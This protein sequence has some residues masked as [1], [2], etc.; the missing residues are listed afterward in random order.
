MVAPIKELKWLI[1][2]AN[3]QLGR[4][5][6]EQLNS[7]EIENYP[8]IRSDLDVTNRDQ[9]KNIFS[10]LKPDVVINTA[11]WTDVE[12]AESWPDEARSINSDAPAYLA[13][14]SKLIGAKFI[15]IS[16]DYV[17][18]GD[19][20][21]PWAE[22]DLPE[23]NSIYGKSKAAGEANVLFEYPESSYI[24][25]TAWLYS[26]FGNNFVK[27]IAHK[28][29]NSE[30]GLKVV[31]D[32]IGQPTCATELSQQIIEMIRV[33]AVPGIYHGTSSGQASWFDLA[34]EIF[35]LLGKDR[36]M[37]APIK[38]V[39]LN[40]KVIRPKYSVLGHE[41]WQ[42]AGLKPMKHWKKALEKALPSI[43]DAIE[44]GK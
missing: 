1:T 26:R 35:S 38:T 40:Q 18:S 17:F 21:K 5:I 11:A 31:N 9:I 4:S 33:D 23:P 32:Q 12:G 14:A 39:E 41:N 10:R 28:A 37:L 20:V 34:Q 6:V 22:S 43:E 27:K 13:K 7:L 29:L 8:L 30:Q 25:R 15:H 44:V 19:S 2:G 42:L 36:S 16:T 3:G 24:V